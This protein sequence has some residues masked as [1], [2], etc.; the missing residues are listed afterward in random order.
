MNESYLLGLGSGPA[1]GK[2]FPWE[3][4]VVC[5]LFLAMFFYFNLRQSLRSEQ[6]VVLASLYIYIH[7]YIYIYIHMGWSSTET[8]ICGPG[9]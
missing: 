1:L 3:G 2:D 7:I 8:N 6:N 9:S 4:T 5:S